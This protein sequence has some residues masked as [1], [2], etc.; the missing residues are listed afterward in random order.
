MGKKILV[1]GGSFK[2][3]G[4]QSKLFVVT[5]MLK[6]RFNDCQV[7]FACN[8]EQ[9]NESDYRFIKVPYT[10]Q[11]QDLILGKGTSILTNISQMIRKKDD[12]STI[13]IRKLFSLIDLIIDISDLILTDRS[14]LAEHKSY[15]DTIRI[16][17]KF[18]I[19]MILMPQSFGPFKDYSLDN[20]DIVK[21][22]M[23]LLF[24]PKA[25]YAREED[26]YDELMGY[27]GLDNLRRSADLV[28][29]TKDL[30]IT[31]VCS[32]LYTPNI[33][34]IKEGNN[35]A[36]IPNNHYFTKKLL[37]HS[38]AFY[39]R[40]IEKL[41]ESKKEVYLFCFSS[42]DLEICKKIAAMFPYNDHVHLIEQEFDSIEY[43]FIIR[44]FD[45]VVCS[46]YHGCVHAYKNLIPGLV[47][48]ST[49]RYRELAKLM[50]QENYFID[51]LSESFNDKP[52]MDAIDYLVKNRDQ[53][54]A[55][56]QNR[57]E[58][59]QSNSCFEI[60]DELGW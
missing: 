44:Y 6:K 45:F 10:R 5:D 42:S 26:G 20:M 1:V 24:Y 4:S 32:P 35:V 7:Y 33:P 9:Y 28:L 17:K 12:G 13:D 2:D 55:V 37:N 25:V 60:L 54:R 16:A 23:D 41:I 27:F 14:T 36:V 39:F 47:L 30:N 43:D 29:Q 38:Y 48:G 15:L 3:K 49:V 59:I 21:E 53:E 58:E 46:R 18:N 50:N 57:L 31:N 19:P 56:I 22:M 11:Y 51:I 34:D 52:W 40:L 8:G